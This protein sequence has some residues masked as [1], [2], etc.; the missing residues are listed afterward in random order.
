MTIYISITDSPQLSIDLYDM[1][2]WAYQ[3]GGWKKY[4]WS[5][6]KLEIPYCEFYAE[7]FN[8]L[9]DIIS[10]IVSNDQLYENIGIYGNDIFD[11]QAHYNVV[12]GKFGFISHPDEL[13]FKRDN[14]QE[15]DDIKSVF[16][17]LCYNYL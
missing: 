4:D 12:F 15:L 14:W 1:R 9:N 6:H 17:Y 11:T 2:L 5:N 7:N 10:I 13:L 3:L 16:G 8:K